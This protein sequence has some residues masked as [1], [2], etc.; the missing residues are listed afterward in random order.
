MTIPKRRYQFIKRKKCENRL[1]ISQKKI[2]MKM[3]FSFWTTLLRILGRKWNWQENNHKFHEIHFWVYYIE[4]YWFWN[5]FVNIVVYIGMYRHR[6]MSVI[7]L[8]TLARS[9]AKMAHYFQYI[10]KTSSLVDQ[11]VIFCLSTRLSSS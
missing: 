5:T 2:W 3:M 7:F 10:D 1:V 4:F 11:N 8:C 6:H 9:F